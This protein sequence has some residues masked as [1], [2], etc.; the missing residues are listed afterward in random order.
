MYRLRSGW[1]EMEMDGLPG[2]MLLDLLDGQG[3]LIDNGIRLPPN[4]PRLT[5]HSLLLM[6][7][8]ISP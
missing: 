6:T 8:A 4:L 3:M 5:P 1:S 2:W 7:G